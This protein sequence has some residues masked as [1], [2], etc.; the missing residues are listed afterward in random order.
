MK[1]R[2]ALLFSTALMAL[3]VLAAC[4]AAPAATQAPIMEQFAAATEAPAE[5][6]A[7]KGTPCLTRRVRAPVTTP[8]T[9]MHDAAART[10]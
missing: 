8:V 1:H 7:E 10:A 3:I 2:F 9:A 5:P 6:L 4:G